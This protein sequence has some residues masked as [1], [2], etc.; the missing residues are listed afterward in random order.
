MIT[1][2]RLEALKNKSSGGAEPPEAKKA[3]PIVRDVG[4]LCAESQVSMTVDEPIKIHKSPRIKK[5]KSFLFKKIPKVS[6]KNDSNSVGRTTLDWIRYNRIIDENTFSMRD[7]YVTDFLAFKTYPVQD[8]TDDIKRI[9][10]RDFWSMLR[11]LSSSDD[12][13]IIFTNYSEDVSMNVEYLKKR[14]A[15]VKYRTPYIEREF[16]HA[17]SQFDEIGHDRQSFKPFLQIFAKNQDDLDHLRENILDY[18]GSYFALSQ[19]SLADKVRLIFKL[20]NP[21]TVTVPSDLYVG[22]DTVGR[23]EGAQEIVGKHEYDPIFLSQI[24]PQGGVSQADNEIIRYGD[25]YLKVLHLYKYRVT[26]DAFWG[27]DVFQNSKYLVTAD[28]KTVNTDGKGTRKNFNSAITEHSDAM[29]K[30]RNFQDKTEAAINYNSVKESAEA[31]T[32]G[33]ETMKQLHTRIYVFEPTREEV[34]SAAERVREK[35]QKRSFDAISFVDEIDDEVKGLF[36]PFAVQ[37]DNRPRKGQEMRGLSLAGSYPFNYSQLIDPTGMYTGYALYSET[38]IVCLDTFHKDKER[39]SYNGIIV[40]G[41]GYGKTTAIKFEAKKNTLVGNYSY[42]FLDGQEGVR[43]AEELGGESVNARYLPV[44]WFQIFASNVDETSGKILEQASFDTN[45]NRIQTTFMIAKNIEQGDYLMDLFEKYLRPFY[46]LWID[47][48][49]LP[50]DTIT[51]QDPHKYP[52]AA[53]FLAYLEEHR[54]DSPADSAAMNQLITKLDNL[55]TSRGEI[56]NQYSMYSFDRQVYA[57]N[58]KDLSS[59]GDS[60]YNAQFYTLVALI[61]NEVMQ[62]GEIQKYQF[63][64]NTKSSD[65]YQFSSIVIDEFHKLVTSKNVLLINQLAELSRELRKMFGGIWVATQHLADCFP[66]KSSDGQ[67]GEMS[68]AVMAMFQSTTYRFLFNQDESARQLI[69]QVFG[70]SI[71]DKDVKDISELKEGQCVFNIRG[72]TTLQFAMQISA[73]DLSIFGGGR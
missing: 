18:S 70:E 25:G 44:N 33:E 42:L 27:Q 15:L 10:I 13:K 21:G 2:K 1:D 34:I 65:E 37:N 60:T 48:N 40:G 39:K 47:A 54:D 5:S 16:Q 43:L 50:M 57:F 4:Q 59:L 31:I 68:K 58:M 72:V 19:V 55:V 67:L 53:D 49:S 36:D 17:L 69:K 73:S 46:E 66:D 23:P 6:K 52:L 24:Q 62:R 30:A 38:G 45:L 41:Q 64:N 35:F 8:S 51:Q 29:T 71:S 12:I 11:G 14:Q 22:S 26:N 32:S 56:F 28:V 3:E 61:T 63:D 9:A 7:G 20:H